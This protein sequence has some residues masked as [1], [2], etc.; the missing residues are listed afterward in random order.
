MTSIVETRDYFHSVPWSLT[1]RCFMYT[2]V[3]P[4]DLLRYL[5]RL[6]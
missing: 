3:L 6:V 4:R 1:V 5:L 2:H